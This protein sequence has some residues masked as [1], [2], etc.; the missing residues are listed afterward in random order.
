MEHGVLTWDSDQRKP[1]V[2][3]SLRIAHC[4]GLHSDF[5]V[6]IQTINVVAKLLGHPIQWDTETVGCDPSLSSIPVLEQRL[7]HDALAEVHAWLDTPENAGEFL[8]IYF[9]DQIDLQAWVSPSSEQSSAHTLE[10]LQMHQQA[11]AN[12]YNIVSFLSCPLPE[13]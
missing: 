9:D 12:G 10:V 1:A 11:H 5:D 7:L 8:V 13:V 2:Q 6:L 4:G 3:G